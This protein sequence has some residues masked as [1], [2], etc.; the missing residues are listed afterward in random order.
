MHLSTA[1]QRA[2]AHASC[3]VS[4]SKDV[5]ALFPGEHWGYKKAAP[6]GHWE[7]S[8]VKTTLTLIITHVTRV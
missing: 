5:V 4:F 7:I 6:T 1:G 2:R 3:P 8:S